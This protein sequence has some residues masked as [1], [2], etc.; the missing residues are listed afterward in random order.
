MCVNDAKSDKEVEKIKN[1]SP[2]SFIDVKMPVKRRWE[3]IGVIFKDGQEVVHAAQR[4]NNK[5][6]AIKDIHVKKLKEA[7]SPV[8]T[9]YDNS[10]TKPPKVYDHAKYLRE[11]ELAE[12]RN[13]KK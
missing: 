1:N 4:T 3:S 6:K 2:K 10:K 11:C 7:N 13:A 8:G 12:G 5:P 9:I